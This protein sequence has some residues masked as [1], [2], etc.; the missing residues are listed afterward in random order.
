MNQ[1]FFIHFLVEGHLDCFQFLA[2]M[3]KAAINIVEQVSLW[4][5]GKYFGDM[6]RSSIAGS[7]GRTIPNF[8]RNCQIDFRSGCPMCTP[9]NNGRMYKSAF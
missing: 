8:L 9:T 4:H 1:S 7:Y 6:P 2:L 3:N 5:G